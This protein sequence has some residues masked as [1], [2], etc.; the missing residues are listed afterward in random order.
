[1]GLHVP[2]ILCLLLALSAVLAEIAKLTIGKSPT[3]RVPVSATPHG[4]GNTVRIC[5]LWSTT[6]TSLTRLVID[7]DKSRAFFLE[8]TKEP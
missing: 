3:A 7:R 6:A 4:K 1:M 2:M 8:R 5:L